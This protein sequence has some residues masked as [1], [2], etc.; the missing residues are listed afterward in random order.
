MLSYKHEV[1]KTLSILIQNSTM[2][3]RFGVMPCIHWVTCICGYEDYDPCNKIIVCNRYTICYKI[4]KS[5]YNKLV[6][7]DNK[8]PWGCHTVQNDGGGPNPDRPLDPTPY[9]LV[10]IQELFIGIRNLVKLTTNLSEGKVELF[11]YCL[12]LSNPLRS[13]Q[14]YRI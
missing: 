5:E 4:N 10:E 7:D 11:I 3:Y 1:A 14:W 8:R 13:P 9:A 6:E 12:Q 2:T